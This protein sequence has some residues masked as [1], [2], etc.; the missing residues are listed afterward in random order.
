MDFLIKLVTTAG[1]FIFW[2]VIAIIVIKFVIKLVWFIWNPSHFLEY[3]REHR[4]QPT[5][6]EPQPTQAQAQ[7]D[8]KEL[9]RHLK[10]S[11]LYYL[12]VFEA[13]ILINILRIT[14]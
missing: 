2:I 1:F 8:G 9:V 11:W 14:Q 12:I 13:F 5:Q 10:A 6:A 4:P 7:A 3:R